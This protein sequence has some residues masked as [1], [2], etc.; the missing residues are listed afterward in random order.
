MATTEQRTGFRLPWAADSSAKT[1]PAPTDGDVGDNAPVG[2]AEGTAVEAEVETSQGADLTPDS[3][4]ESALED[5]MVRD[6][7]I[8]N[9]DRKSTR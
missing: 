5:E 6:S 1:D 7:F 4:D 9:L 8:T 2:S 3:A